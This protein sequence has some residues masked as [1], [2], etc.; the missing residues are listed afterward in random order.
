MSRSTAGCRLTPLRRRRRDA[1]RATGS[2]SSASSATS[3]ASTSC[4]EAMKRLAERGRRRAPLAPR[5]QPRAPAAGV[6][7]RVRRRCSRRSGDRVDLGR[8]L[9]PRRAAEADGRR[10]LGRGAVDLVGELAAGDPGGLHARPAGDLQRHRRHGREGHRRRRRPALPGR[11]PRSLARDDRAAAGSPQLWRT[12]CARRHRASPTRWNG[13]STAI[14]SSLYRRAARR[15]A[16]LRSWCQP[17]RLRRLATD[18]VRYPARRPNRRLDRGG[19]WSPCSTE[20]A[21]SPPSLARPPG[22]PPARMPRARACS[23]WPAAKVL[24]SGDGAGSAARTAKSPGRR[25]PEIDS[26]PARRWRRRASTCGDVR[27]SGWPPRARDRERLEFFEDDG[28]RQA[29]CI[30]PLG[31]AKSLCADPRG[32]ARPL[33]AGGVDRD[34]PQGL[35]VGAVS[36]CRRRHLLRPRLGPRRAGAN[37]SPRRRLAPRD[38]GRRVSSGSSAYPRPDLD[39]LLTRRRA[40]RSPRHRLRLATSRAAR[41]AA[42][43]EGWVFELGELRRRRDQRPGAPRRAAT[44]CASR[45][46]DPRRARPRAARR[47]RR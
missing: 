9:R 21:S 18:D 31:L 33:P 27:A 35:H 36:P 44:R 28:R 29:P 25:H 23:T 7:G 43:A 42:L 1:A 13:T 20:R 5:R 47:T 3:R 22:V 12:D 30:D 19:R 24:R 14:C 34:E 2:A 17:A 15:G 26:V 45:D 39:Q 4:C 46:D 16:A 10:R 11:R 6:P 41:P 40:V 38:R 32:A 37:R 8:P